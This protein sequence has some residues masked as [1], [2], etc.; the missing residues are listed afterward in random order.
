MIRKLL[1]ALGSVVALVAV[2]VGTVLALGTRN[3]TGS[4]DLPN[5]AAR[6]AGS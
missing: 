2:A 4:T 3:L 6:P 5:E 1:L